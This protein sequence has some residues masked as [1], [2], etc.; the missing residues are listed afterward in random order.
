MTSNGPTVHP[1][2]RTGFDRAAEAY[3]RARPSYPDGAVAWLR[4]R[5]DLRPGRTVVDLAAGTGKLTMLLVPT[6]ARIVAVEPV[7]G[8]RSVLRVRAHGSNVSVVAGVAEALPLADGV[9]DAVTVAQAFH[10][11]RDAALPELH[12]VLRPGG[13]LA[14]VWNRRDLTDPVWA[15]VKDLIDPFREGTPHH[16]ADGW[17]ALFEGTGL[18]GPLEERRFGNERCMRGRWPYGR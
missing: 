9:A 10:W 8:M 14:L 6:G 7:G 15:A 13:V 2:A 4:E 5:L 17:R 11:F 12:R 3:E 16:E 18:F 1:A